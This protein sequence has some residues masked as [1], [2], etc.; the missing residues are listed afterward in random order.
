M[1]KREFTQK[2]EVS[3]MENALL[4]KDKHAVKTTHVRCTVCSETVG[5]IH[6]NFHAFQKLVL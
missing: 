3:N 5:L 4:K 6:F 1:H 2:T